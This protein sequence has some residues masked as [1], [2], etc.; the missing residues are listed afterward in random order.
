MVLQG[1]ALVEGGL[2]P[3]GMLSIPQW[4]R[5]TAMF[6]KAAATQCRELEIAVIHTPLRRRTIIERRMENG[7]SC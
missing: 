2:D 1:D 4:E 7:G 5:Y 3:Q 6:P